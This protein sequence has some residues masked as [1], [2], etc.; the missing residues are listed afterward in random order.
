[1]NDGVRGLRYECQEA[2]DDSLR[3]S[4]LVNQCFLKVHIGSLALVRGEIHMGTDLQL[5]FS[6]VFF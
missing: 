4:S 1:M 2:S 3:H 5:Q 6:M